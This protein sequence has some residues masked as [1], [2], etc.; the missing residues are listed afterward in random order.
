MTIQNKRVESKNFECTQQS[1]VEES[2]LPSRGIAVLPRGVNSGEVMAATY[3]LPHVSYNVLI[4]YMNIIEFIHLA[5]IKCEEVMNLQ[6][7]Y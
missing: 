3:L 7:S 5:I 6:E 4:L 1:G 2:L